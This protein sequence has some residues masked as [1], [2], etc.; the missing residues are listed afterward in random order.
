[1]GAGRAPS[2]VIL[3]A[4]S[5]IRLPGRDGMREIFMQRWA[6]GVRFL[7]LVALLSGAG[8][9][10][11]AREVV[12]HHES[13]AVS[14]RFKVDAE[15]RKNGLYRSYREDGSLKLKASYRKGELSGRYEELHPNGKRKLLA[16]YLAGT[17][18]P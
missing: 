1:M 5:G 3:Q 10:S 15:G 7:L 13:G 17:G 16:T 11:Q 4:S 14:A 18:V 8:L 2:W 9:R 12:E 6:G